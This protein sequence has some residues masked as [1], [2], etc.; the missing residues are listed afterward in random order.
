MTARVFL[1]LA[2]SVLLTVA[3]DKSLLRAQPQVHWIVYPFHST[4][5]EQIRHDL[6][7]WIRTGQTFD[8]STLM[9]QCETL[10][11]RPS[12]LSLANLRTI[13]IW[14]KRATSHLRTRSISSSFIRSPGLSVTRH[15]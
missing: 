9:K 11:P 13:R 1:G 2:L 3:S 8:G 14:T 12:S 6:N 4:A 15:F 5:S 10:R 7:V